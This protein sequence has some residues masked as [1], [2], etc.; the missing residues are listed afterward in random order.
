MMKGYLG[1]L[2]ICIFSGAANA[3]LIY[4][5]AI[6][7]DA[8]GD[9]GSG[10]VIGV[11]LGLL[12]LGDSTVMGTISGGD[13]DWFKFSI[14]SGFTLDSITITAFSGPGGN[15]GWANN[16]IDIDVDHNGPF[17]SSL[18]GTDLLESAALSAISGSFGAG[19]YAIKLGTGSNVNSYTFD[20]NVSGPASVPEPASIALLAFG[21]AGISFSRKKKNI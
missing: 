5:E 2:L 20:F 13:D 7:G 10:I 6:D 8:G 18:I 19:S 3:G 9:N 17:N 14:G 11:N 21:L 15:L 4:N 12:T 1:L 16:G